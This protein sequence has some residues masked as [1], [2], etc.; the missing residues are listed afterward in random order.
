MTVPNEEPLAPTIDGHYISVPGYNPPDIF[1]DF[2]GWSNYIG[3]YFEILAQALLTLDTQIFTLQTSIQE[4]T[5]AVEINTEALTT[6]QAETIP[7]VQFAYSNIL[8]SIHNLNTAVFYLNNTDT[9]IK[10]AIVTLRNRVSILEQPPELLPD[11]NR[12]AAIVEQNVIPPTA[13]RPDSGGSDARIAEMI[14]GAIAILSE[15]IVRLEQQL[16]A[17]EPRPV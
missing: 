5:T 12:I 8:P 2:L 3:I 15:S 6:Q 13:P 9:A 17:V 14:A 11:D 16:S 10:H 4:L 7:T 1:Q